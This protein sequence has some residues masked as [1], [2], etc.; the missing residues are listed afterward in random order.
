KFSGRGS[1]RGAG[2]NSLWLISAEGAD[3]PL[4]N[5]RSGRDGKLPD[6]C[7]R[8]VRQPNWHKRLNPTPAAFAM[9]PTA[10]LRPR[11]SQQI[12]D[13]EFLTVRAKIL[14]LAAALDRIERGA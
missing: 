10:K 11:S 4:N 9:L 12:L 14:E 5:L 1:Q 8:Y 7:K 6:R 13:D 3:A 2:S